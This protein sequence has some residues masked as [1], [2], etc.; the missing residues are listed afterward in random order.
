MLPL[1]AEIVEVPTPAAVAKPVLLIVATVVVPEAHTTLFNTCVLPSPNVPVAVN[2]CVKPLAI[3]GFKGVTTIDTNVGGVTVKRV[4]P[5]MLPLFAEIVEVPTP[6]AVAKPVLLIVATVV[7]PEAHTTLFNTC[8][9]PSPNVPVAVNCC[10][11]PL[12]IVGFTGVTPIDTNV[13]GV[14]VKRV[15]PVMLPLF[16]EIVEVPTPAA[17]AKPVLLIVA[18]VVV[19]EAHTTLFNT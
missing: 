1:V 10:V 18:T 12:A 13:G 5:V 17:V 16:A 2:C 9:L 11:K 8:V 7:V 15:A 19:P 4:D 14:T 6:A 3:V